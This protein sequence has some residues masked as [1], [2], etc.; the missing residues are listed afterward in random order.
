MGI[1]ARGIEA[2][3]SLAVFG[4]G[5]AGILHIP[6]ALGEHGIEAPVEENAET[7]VGKF[8]TR[9]EIFGSG[10]VFLLRKGVGSRERK[11]RRGE[12]QTGEEVFH[13]IR[14]VLKISLV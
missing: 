11:Q 1:E 4:I 7:H 12:Q 9:L 8:L 13:I 10:H 3:R 14:G 6:F 2:R 5:D